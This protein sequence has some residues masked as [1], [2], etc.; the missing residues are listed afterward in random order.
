MADLTTSFTNTAWGDFPKK[1]QFTDG[2]TPTP[3]SRWWDFGDGHF[4]TDQNP[5]HQYWEEGVHD[6]TL[7]TRNDSTDNV[8]SSDTSSSA[9][10]MT[11]EDGKENLKNTDL[12]DRG[13]RSYPPTNNSVSVR[14]IEIDPGDRGAATDPIVYY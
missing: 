2:S 5:N 12:G 3:D 1:V 8:F 6:V 7:Y 14:P 10:T 4:C 9:V 13:W 11:A